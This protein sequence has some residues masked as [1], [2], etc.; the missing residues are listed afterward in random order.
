MNEVEI[1]N[2]CAMAPGGEWLVGRAQPVACRGAFSVR[3]LRGLIVPDRTFVR[4][5]ECAAASSRTP[6]PS[7]DGRAGSMNPPLAWF[8]RSDAP[9][10]TRLD[11]L[12]DEPLAVVSEKLLVAPWKSRVGA[13]SVKLVPLSFRRATLV[14]E[15]RF[16]WVVAA[17]KSRV[18]R[19]RVDDAQTLTVRPEAVVAWV[20]K[21]PTG[22]CPKLSLLDI[23]LPRGPRNLAFTFHGP[24]TVW[25]EGGHEVLN[26]RK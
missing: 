16:G 26:L 4:K 11:A 18:T 2:G 21:P 23:L 8:A 25:F 12:P 9:F 5:M 6:Y 15:F 19:V 1:V 20:G 14:T 7:D 3:S 24:C 22:F 13:R 10:L 17:T